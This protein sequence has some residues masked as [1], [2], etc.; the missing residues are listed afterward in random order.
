MKTLLKALFGDWANCAVAVLALAVAAAV[1]YLG[2][3]HLASWLLPV[4]LMLGAGYLA[5]RYGRA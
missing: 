1:R 2:D 5:S 3:P 4:V